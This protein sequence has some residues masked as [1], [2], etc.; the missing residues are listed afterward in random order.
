MTALLNS[1]NTIYNSEYNNNYEFNYGFV[2]GN[3]EFRGQQVIQ[4]NVA[5]Q[6]GPADDGRTSMVK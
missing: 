6:T 1:D 2:A 3:S 5:S 4:C